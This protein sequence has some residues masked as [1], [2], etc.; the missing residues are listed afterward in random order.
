MPAPR[1]VVEPLSLPCP[2]NAGRIGHAQTMTTQV[3]TQTLNSQN[4]A[5]SVS[6]PPRCDFAGFCDYCG[7]QGCRSTDC[8]AMYFDTWWAACEICGGVGGDGLGASCLC[9]YGVVQVGSGRGGAVQ[10]R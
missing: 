4:L 7:E 1:A 6:P 5:V 2:S 3:V 9:T 10:P 8:V